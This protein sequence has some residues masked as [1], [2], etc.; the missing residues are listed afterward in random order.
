MKNP[1]KNRDTC[2]RAVK[3]KIAA[4]RRVTG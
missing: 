3:D 2:V 4:E 1:G